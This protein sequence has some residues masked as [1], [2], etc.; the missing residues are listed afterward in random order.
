MHITPLLSGSL[1]RSS[2][3]VS[4]IFDFE[5]LEVAE[6]LLYSENIN[7]FYLFKNY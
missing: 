4:F 1:Q 7:I 6:A 5:E 3:K 2:F